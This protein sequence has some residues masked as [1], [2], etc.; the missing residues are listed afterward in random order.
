MKVNNKLKPIALAVAAAVYAGAGWAGETVDLGNDLKLDWKLTGT[1]TASQRMK[2]PSPKLLAGSDGDKNFKKGDMTANRLSAL[3]ESRLYKGGSGLVL[4]ASTF[5]DAVY[6]QKNANDYG[7]AGKPVP[8]N[9][10]TEQARRYHGGYS[11]ILDAYAYTSFGF[12]EQG[13]ATV[14]LGRHVVN[15][16][17]ATYMA[18]IAAAQGPFDGTKVGIAGTEVKDQVLPEDQISAAIEI[19]PRLTLLAQLQFGYH[20]TIVSAPGSFMSN[21]NVVGPGASCTGNYT[22]SVCGGFSRIDDDQPSDF[23]QWGI[24]SRYRVTDETEVGLYFLNY[25][26]RNPSVDIDFGT[27]KYR[28]KYFDNVKLL[29]STVSTTF[30]PV[31]AYGEYTF[32][33]GTPVMVGVTNTPTR[34]KVSQLNIGGFYNIGRTAIADQVQLLG[35]FAA[36]KV[37][38][39]TPGVPTGYPL[40]PSTSNSFRTD[41]SLAF[42]GTLVLGYPGISEGWDLTVPISYS[43]QLRGRALQGSV[44]GQ[45][46]RRYS[47]GAS[48]V[49]RGNLA[50]GVTYQGYLGSASTDARANRLWADRDQLS[51]TAKYT[52]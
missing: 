11:R 18:N 37:H 1:Y 26:E 51:L 12:G 34:A 9:E 3:W 44:G 38:S 41:S 22:G 43:H 20:P 19:N 10:F 8:F 46:E 29:G 50:L 16:G 7:Y 45:G 2:D 30:G 13:N 25:K 47:V 42:S 35:E 52:F 28:I 40:P 32:R 39:I 31:S 23:G 36:T 6:H 17:E 33:D 14:R 15:W 4:S 27:G 5:Y 21:S 49:Y 48:F 24:G